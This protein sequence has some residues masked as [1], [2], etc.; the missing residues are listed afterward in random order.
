MSTYNILSDLDLPLVLFLTVSVAAVDL[1]GV[2][3]E[4]SRGDYV[5]AVP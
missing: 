1:L 5:D 3:S 2:V 4:T